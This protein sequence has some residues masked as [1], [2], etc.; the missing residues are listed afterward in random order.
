MH[1]LLL[2]LKVDDSAHKNVGKEILETLVGNQS[3]VPSTQA[4]MGTLEHRKTVGVPSLTL[5]S[6]PDRFDS[7]AQFILFSTFLP[8]IWSKNYSRR[9]CACWKTNRFRLLDLTLR[10]ARFLINVQA[11][12]V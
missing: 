8:V 1:D 3:S 4:F 9:L 10:F 7:G 11:N 12:R 2:L 5:L 6:K